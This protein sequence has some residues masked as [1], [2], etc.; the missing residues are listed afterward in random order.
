MVMVVEGKEEE[1]KEEGAALFG[2]G[3]NTIPNVFPPTIPNVAAFVNNQIFWKEENPLFVCLFVLFYLLTKVH[4]HT[5]TLV[6]LAK[7]PL[8]PSYSGIIN[9]IS[10]H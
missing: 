10:M 2:G 4:V 1:E 5:C 8:S 3:T 7:P 9:F 6:V